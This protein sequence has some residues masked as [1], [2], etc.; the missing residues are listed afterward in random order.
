MIDLPK[1]FLRCI[2]NRAADVVYLPVLCYLTKYI[3]PLLP[4]KEWRIAHVACAHF[5]CDSLFGSSIYSTVIVFINH[6]VVNIVPSDEKNN[7][8]YKASTHKV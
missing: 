3:L 2:E 4:F 1:I 7:N 6:R 8:I 5:A